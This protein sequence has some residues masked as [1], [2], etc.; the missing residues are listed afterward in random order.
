MARRAVGIGNA[1]GLGDHALEIMARAGGICFLAKIVC[2]CH[3]NLSIFASISCDVGMLLSRLLT[4]AVVQALAAGTSTVGDAD[5]DLPSC[6]L[7]LLILK[8]TG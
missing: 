1:V 3:C 6:E 8:K 4:S 2:L 5:L 7:C